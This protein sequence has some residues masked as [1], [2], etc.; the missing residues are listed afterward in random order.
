MQNA[1]ISQEIFHALEQLFI[2][3]PSKLGEEPLI[4]KITNKICF[5]ID[6]EFRKQLVLIF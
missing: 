2:S 3:L 4:C 1:K 6:N 5:L